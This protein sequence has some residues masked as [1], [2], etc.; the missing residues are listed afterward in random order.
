MARF[1]RFGMVGVIGFAVAAGVLQALM[2]LGLGPVGARAIAI[3]VAVLATWSLNRTFTF[4]Q[5]QQGPMLASL[6]RYVAVSATGAAVNFAVYTA[7]VLAGV[8]PF[9]ALA[10]ASVTA[11]FVNYLGS[12]HFAFRS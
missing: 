8:P 4:P 6:A 1:V 11:M 2:A 3:P 5:A 7:L 9:A 10:V 12:K